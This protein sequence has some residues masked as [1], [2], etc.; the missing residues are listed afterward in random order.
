MC[1]SVCWRLWRV[2]SG[3]GGAGGDTL[4]AT[5]HAAGE[6]PEVMRCVLLCMLEAGE[7]TFCL[8][9]CWCYS[10]CWKLWRVRSGFGGVGGVGGVGGD[11]LCATLHAGGTGGDALKFP[12]RQFSRYNPQAPNCVLSPGS[13]FEPSS[14]QE[15]AGSFRPLT[16][17]FQREYA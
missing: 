16:I 10:V 14:T 6:V 13:S 2:R 5:L 11:T 9:R 17:D 7:G 4:C 8:W 3:F 1:Y 12:L 15:R